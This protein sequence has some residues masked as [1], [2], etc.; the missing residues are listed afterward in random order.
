[1]AQGGRLIHL[2]GPGGAG[3]STV[4]PILAVVLEVPCYDLDAHFAATH[5]SVDAFIA[6]H[7]YRA[8]AAANVRAYFGLA[9]AATGVAALS[10]GFMVYP[11]DVDSRYEALWA[12]LATAR[13]TVVLLPALELEA[14][15]AETVRRQVT[16]G[17]GRT[18]AARADAKIRERFPLYVALPAL[19]VATARPPEAVAADIAALISEP[20]G[21]NADAPSNDS[22][23]QT[24][25]RRSY[26]G[27]VLPWPPAAQFRR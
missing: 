14:C 26:A 16:R 3:K 24:G 18:T 7:G 19:K 21:P 20:T 1:M 17:A 23:E 2:V 12:A 11:P 15:V 6:A 22:L 13:T 9:A 25:G 4:A 27:P 10:S 5:G 8:Y